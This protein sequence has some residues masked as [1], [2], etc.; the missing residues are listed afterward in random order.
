MPPLLPHLWQATRRGRAGG[1][2]GLS[3]CVTAVE[4]EGLSGSAAIWAW[5]ARPEGGD[6]DGTGAG[7]GFRSTSP[8]KMRDRGSK[9]GFL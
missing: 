3:G 4:L 8:A 2:G 1:G 7:P 9:G 5:A 6:L